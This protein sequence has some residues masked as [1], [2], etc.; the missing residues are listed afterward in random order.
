MEL[1]WDTFRTIQGYV[2]T[3]AVYHHGITIFIVGSEDK[4]KGQRK[5]HCHSENEQ[6]APQDESCWAAESHFLT[7]S[8]RFV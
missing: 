6:E 8:Q 1:L 5:H 3:V 4:E 7:S 2:S